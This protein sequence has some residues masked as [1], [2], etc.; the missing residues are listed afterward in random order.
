[1]ARSIDQERAYRKDVLNMM[2]RWNLPEAEYPKGQDGYD[3]VMFG[4]YFATGLKFSFILNNVSGMLLAVSTAE[5]TR[6]YQ[7]NDADI[8]A[9]LVITQP[10]WLKYKVFFYKGLT[11][12]NLLVSRTRGIRRRSFLETSR[13][14]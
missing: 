1:M 2:E 6:I 4:S 7:Q 12:G 9:G 13:S 10:Y 3:T 14:S 5:S 8:K 11:L